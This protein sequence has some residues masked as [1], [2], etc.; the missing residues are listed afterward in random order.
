MTR[1]RAMACALALIVTSV[2]AGQSTFENLGMGGAGGI[3]TPAS[4]PVDPDFLLA[5]SDMSGCY[6]SDDGG[7]SW[8]MIHH[9]QIKSAHRCKPAFHPTD[10]NV[11]VWKGRISQDKAR[12]FEPLVAG[13][14]PRGDPTHNAIA[15]D[16][17]IYVGSAAGIWVGRE[18]EPFARAADGPCGG[19][20]ILP[21]DTVIAAAG[22]AVLRSPAGHALERVEI[23]SPGER[24]RAIAAGGTA[25]SHT[26]HALTGSLHTSTTTP[27]G[28]ATCRG[29]SSR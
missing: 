6:R 9:L 8:D 23:P 7:A 26:I 18:G 27:M 11:V 13:R 4:S 16:R 5:S 22:D 10:V 2:A 3:F 28:R 24:I 1:T 17:T 21:D 19:I 14:A 29:C 20:T 25:A 15:R 12:T